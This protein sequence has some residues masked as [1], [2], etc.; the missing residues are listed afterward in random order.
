[1]SGIDTF[2]Q[3]AAA[4]VVAE[5]R[6]KQLQRA[7]ISVQ[8]SLKGGCSCHAVLPFSIVIYSYKRNCVRK[9]PNLSFNIKEAKE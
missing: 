7:C 5:S 1:M 8:E 6:Q 9:E 4:V 2:A 3:L